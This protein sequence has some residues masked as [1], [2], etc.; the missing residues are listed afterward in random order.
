MWQKINDP[1]NYM[2]VI[3]CG[4][5]MLWFH[6]SRKVLVRVGTTKV[7]LKKS[8]SID[9][10]FFDK[11]KCDIKN[12]LWEPSPPF[13]SKMDLSLFVCLFPSHKAAN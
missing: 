10:A 1:L 7:A 4:E 11:S 9:V 5:F 6:S 12:E 3:W 13:R 2:R 8:L